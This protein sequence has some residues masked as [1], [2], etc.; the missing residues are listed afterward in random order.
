MVG[1]VGTLS[2]W[3]VSLLSGD[4]WIVLLQWSESGKGAVKGS[5]I[6]TLKDSLGLSSNNQV[7]SSPEG[8]GG[9]Y[10]GRQSCGQKETGSHAKKN[11]LQ[12]G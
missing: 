2:E 7:G 4:V 11:R 1:E 3:V 5:W 8:V 12:E 6:L 9:G 10:D